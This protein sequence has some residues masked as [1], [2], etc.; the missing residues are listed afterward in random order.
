MV[1]TVILMCGPAG[2]GKTTYAR[3]L[4]AQGATRL[5][6]DEEYWRRGFRGVHPVPRQLATEVQ[7][8]LD[9]RLAEAVG[10]GDV[11]LDYAFST[12]AVRDEY[13]ALA[14]SLG[15]PTRLI[16]VTAPMEVLEA[17]VRARTG[18]HADDARLDPDVLRGYVEGFEAPTADEH[19]EVVSTDGPA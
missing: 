8:D 12:R 2:A 10:Q 13:R 17:R 3:R 11:V 6:Y 4:E 18:A 19:P 7:H 15:A 1:G 5:S 16:F 14:A 9:A